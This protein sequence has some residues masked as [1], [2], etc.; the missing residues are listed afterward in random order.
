MST[1]NWESFLRQWSRDF[2]ESAGQAQEALPPDVVASGWLGYPGATEEQI[3]RAEARL[4]I[5][6]PTS[7]REFLK[8]SNGWRQTTPFI[9]RL[10]STEEIEWFSVRHQAWID[11][12]VERFM[13][14]HLASSDYRSGIEPISD[15]EYLVYGE[16]Q[17]CG[18]LRP[19][20]LQTALEIS[21]AGDAAI[22][23]L[24]PQVVAEDGEW[25]A[26]FFGTW[27]PGADRYRSFHEMMQVEYANFLELRETASATFTVEF[28]RRQV[29]ER[30]ERRITVHHRQ[31]NATQTWSD[32]EPEPLRQWLLS[33]LKPSGLSPEEPAVPA[34]LEISQV[35]VFQPPQAQIPVRLGEPHR[36]F[37]GYLRSRVPFALEVSFRLSVSTRTVRQYQNASYRVECYVRNRTAGVTIHLGDTQSDTLVEGKQ[38]Y[39]ARLPVAML[40]SS[41]VYCLQI[42]VTFKGVVTAL[43]Y[44]E[45]PLL[46]VI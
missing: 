39:T 18:K 10:W 7:Y 14:I 12:F 8:V 31:T 32:L 17:D 15:E 24:N 1:F 4:G 42:I 37:S 3:A 33:Q 25:E 45:I 27:L 23:L 11:D 9:Y 6:L 21:D 40:Q 22:Y 28:Q 46:Q 20:Y 16:Q 2:L 38:V 19:E 36:P 44:F 29:E 35:Q 5:T 43:G 34:S 26:W 13:D 30:T 41:G